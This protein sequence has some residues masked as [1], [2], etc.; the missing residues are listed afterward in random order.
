MLGAG[1]MTDAECYAELLAQ[2]Y[3]CTAA[4]ERGLRRTTS[5]LA[6]PAEAGRL[7]FTS[8]YEADRGG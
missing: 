7:A 2:F 3:V 8:G 4:L 6:Q 5:K 1:L